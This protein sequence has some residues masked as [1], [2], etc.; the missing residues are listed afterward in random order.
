MLSSSNPNKIQIENIH[1]TSDN[2]V[3]DDSAVSILTSFN[4]VDNLLQSTS[5]SSEETSVSQVLDSNCNVNMLTDE[6]PCKVAKPCK[7]AIILFILI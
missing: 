6:S 3:P 5:F 1:N 7:R 2:F 4:Q